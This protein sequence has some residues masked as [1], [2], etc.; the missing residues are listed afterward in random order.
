MRRLDNLTQME[1]QMTVAQT[2]HVAADSRVTLQDVQSTSRAT[3]AIVRECA[4]WILYM[5]LHPKPV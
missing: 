3:L 2:L 1:L 4:S 5:K